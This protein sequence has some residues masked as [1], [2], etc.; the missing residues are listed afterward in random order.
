MMVYN[1]KYV[2]L[3]SSTSVNK[4]SLSQLEV[5]MKTLHT[6]ILNALPFIMHLD[7]FAMFTKGR[8]KISILHSLA[9]LISPVVHAE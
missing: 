5:I 8:V 7:M 2:M 4:I 1:Y 6:R 3:F 9:L